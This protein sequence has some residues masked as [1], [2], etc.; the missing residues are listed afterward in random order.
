MRTFTEEQLIKRR[1][2]TAQWQKD[3]RE[4]CNE[5]SKRWRLANPDKMK[6]AQRRSQIKRKYGITLEE[7]GVMFDKQQGEC[8]IC[9]SIQES[10]ALAVDHCHINGKVRG[11]LCENCNTGLGKFKDDPALLKK[12]L[13]WLERNTI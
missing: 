2:T 4:K 11:L 10:K 7:Y 12:G 13:E 5:R 9:H 3:N 8:G 1:E 6:L